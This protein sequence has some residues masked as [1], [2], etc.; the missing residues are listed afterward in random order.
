MSTSL[1][2]S[3]FLRPTLGFEWLL[4]ALE[5]QGGVAALGTSPSYDIS[6]TGENSYRISVAVPGFAQDE[7]A[8]TQEQNMLVVSGKK[9]AEQNVQ[10][11]YR[12]INDDSFQTR[13]Q[14]ADHVTVTGA[15]L[16]NGVLT[17]ELQRELPEEMKP[18]QIAIATSQPT[19]P[20]EAKQ[21]EADKQAA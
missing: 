4:N 13:F 16:A 20:Q 7:L 1:D 17:I 10:Y 19:T 5:P 2:F 8:I 15:D 18:R 14:L 6:R 12:G 3:P 9:T 11:L 21:I